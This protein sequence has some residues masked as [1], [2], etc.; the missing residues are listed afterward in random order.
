MLQGFK[1]LGKI[2]QFI[3]ARAKDPI[4]DLAFS[5]STN[6]TTKYVKNVLKNTNGKSIFLNNDDFKKAK[7]YARRNLDLSLEYSS[8]GAIAALDKIGKKEIENKTVIL[9]LT[10]LGR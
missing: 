10:A 5:I 6:S 3:L 4:G 7:S 9:I 8:A 1:E 2:P